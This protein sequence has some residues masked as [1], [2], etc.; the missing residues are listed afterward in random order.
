MALKSRDFFILASSIALVS[1]AAL[2]VTAAEP[3]ARPPLMFLEYG[4]GPNRL[5]EIDSAGKL[6]GE[7]K[8]PSIAVIFQVLANGNVVYAYGGH[9]TGV[10]RN[11][12]ERYGSL[13]LCEQVS[14]SSRLRAS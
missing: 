9:P 10:P 14:P 7:H 2:P 13:E 12:E 6:V 8:P 3:S 11:H 4:K 5:L 1:A